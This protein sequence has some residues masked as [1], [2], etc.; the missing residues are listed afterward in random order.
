M[1]KWTTVVTQES[2]QLFP[3]DKPVLRCFQIAALTFKFSFLT[4]RLQLSRMSGAIPSLF[5]TKHIIGQIALVV[6]EQTCYQNDGVC[7]NRPFRSDYVLIAL[8]Q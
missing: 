1:K 6:Q 8:D 5:G 2:N 4:I 3:P 7:F